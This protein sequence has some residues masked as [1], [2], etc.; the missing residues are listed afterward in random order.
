MRPL[1]GNSTHI[2]AL[3]AG[4]QPGASRVPTPRRSAA[5]PMPQAICYW[6]FCGH[7]GCVK[8]LMNVRVRVS[9]DLAAMNAA[10]ILHPL[11]LFGA[12]L[13]LSLTAL[14]PL[15][16]PGLPAGDDAILHLYRAIVLDHSLTYDGTLWPRY[17]S[18]LAYGYGAA[19]FNHFPPTAY[20][21]VVLF[22]RLGLEY[23]AAYKLTLSAYILLAGLGAYALGRSWSTPTG[24]LLT[25]AAT[26][27]APYWMFDLVTRST[28][29]ELAALGILSW[30]LWALHQLAQHNRRRDFLLSVGSVALIVLTHNVI[31]LHAALLI[32]AY[33]L[34][35]IVR[36]PQ[37]VRVL[38]RLAVAGVLAL[39]VTTFFWWPALSEIDYTKVPGTTE[40]L[41]FI[42]V[43]RTLRP[44]DAILS[45]PLTAD[46]DQL[47]RPVAIALGWPQI[48][49]AAFATLLATRAQRGLVALLVGAT[50]VVIFLNTP[51]SAVV[52]ST[53]PLLNFSQFAWRT[54]GIAAL[55]LALLAGIGGARLLHQLPS[56]RA[57]TA[58][59]AVFLTF[60]GVYAIPWLYVPYL[61]DLPAES[62]LDA[63]AHER[64]TGQLTLS[65]YSEYLTAWNTAPLDPQRLQ[66]RFEQ[67]PVIPRLM[68]PPGVIINAADWGGTSVT[69]DITTESEAELVFDWLYV[70]GWR[71]D[72]NGEQ[73]EISPTSPEGLISLTVPQGTHQV[74]LTYT[75]TD[76]QM[77]TEL[78]SLASLV[79]IGL[80]TWGWPRTQRRQDGTSWPGVRL[81]LVTAAVGIG[82]LLFK[83]LVID[84]SQ[85][86]LRAERFAE[87]AAGVENALERDFSRA[88]TLIGITGPESSQA[89]NLARFSLFWRLSG[90][91]LDRDL[92]TRLSLHNALGLMVAETGSFM[93]GDLATSNWLPGFYV[94]ER[95]KLDVPPTLPPGDYTL[96]LLVYDAETL[97]PLDVLNVA[98]NPEG[99]EL[100]LGSLRI[101]RSEQPMSISTVHLFT[102]GG[103]ELIALEGLPQRAMIG[104]ELIIDWLWRAP[105]PPDQPL[106]AVIVWRSDAAAEGTASAP[107][108]LTPD[109]P[110]SDWQ[111]GDVWRD[112]VRVYVPATL[113][114]TEH[115]LHLRLIDADGQP[116]AESGPLAQMAVTLP[117]RQTS[118]PDDLT[119]EEINWENGLTLRGYSWDATTQ[120]L[121]LAWATTDT[122]GRS[123]RLFVH[124]TQ[125]DQIAQVRDGVP[126]AGQ[127]PTTGWI[128]GEF[129][130]TTH[131]FNLPEGGYE[132]RI[133]W[134]DP[135]T[136]ERIPLTA[137]GDTRDLLSITIP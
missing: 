70:P 43:T 11:A 136:G 28:L 101:T 116:I 57:K 130:V 12:L 78:I 1:F 111:A 9:G 10:R 76:L 91:R 74:R 13:V 46:P 30:A 22:H 25:A 47:Q 124:A 117:E 121:S 60:M 68:P 61:R 44:L 33:S 20:Y 84:R 8:L 132:L 119:A 123:L 122:L 58:L 127:R 107:L 38:L 75:G 73:L 99:V 23:I 104:D 14:H 66:S 7:V 87:G 29:T 45:P 82:L 49:L 27:Y 135:L 67:N 89:G 129:I 114:A 17:S 31:A 54:L 125:G 110:V 16:Q 35:L 72:L 36:H 103:L 126:L 53:V 2:A 94:E 83:G 40:A 65:S 42:D 26:I 80:V 18:A 4:Y 96:R 131:T 37:R 6:H 133:G 21:P 3:T 51:A 69:I 34:F 137:G 128:T 90:N 5:R 97:A 120:T 105:A 71:A 93:P 113:T 52:W 81:L 134:Y 102:G 112:R 39:L 92:S 55:T 108:A 48:A 41:G 24:G 19:L 100:D 118:L 77:L 50:L 63:Q 15:M 85:N 62:V 109:F 86:L 56:K 64:L 88:V 98:G 79:I 106:Q 59:F 32:A 115:T 95:L